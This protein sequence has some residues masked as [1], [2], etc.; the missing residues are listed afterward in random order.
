M[1]AEFRAALEELGR[2]NGDISPRLIARLS[3]GDPEDVAWFRDHFGDLDAAVRAATLA[4]MVESAETDYE[5]DYG[6]LY[7]VALEDNSPDVR[8]R[9]V[10]GLWEDERLDLIRRLLALL[11]NDASDEVRAAAATSLGRFVYMAEC[12][13]VDGDR[14]M[15]L[16]AALLR[17][18]AEQSLDVARRALESLAYINDE[19]V[20]RLIYQAY[21]HDHPLMRQS[22]VF[23][24]GRSADRFWSETVLAE[25][26]SDDAA[27]RFE[28]ARAA[29][30]LRLPRALPVLARLVARDRDAEVQSMA[31]W[32]LGEIGGRRAREILERLAEGDDEA[33]SVAAHEALEAMDLGSPEFD[34]FIFEPEEGAEY[35]P[36]HI[37]SGDASGD[38]PDPDEDESLEEHEEEDLED[39]S[40]PGYRREFER[41]TDEDD[42]SDE[43]DDENDDD[44][45]D[46]FLELT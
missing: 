36:A 37:H 17:A 26:H 10:E 44:W 12:D 11:E 23:A 6:E 1:T 46:E 30:E 18:V 5:L 16:R 41:Y 13:L 45:I 8:R 21:A 29:G 31:I 19:S 32:A 4:A 3:S 27:M 2:I 33:Q 38:A 35:V 14:A 34:M 7:R 40:L 22:A 39:D 9:A 43:D 20:T 15:R 25:L 42:D 24:M 28:A